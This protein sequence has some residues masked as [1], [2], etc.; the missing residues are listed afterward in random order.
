MAHMTR[1]HNHPLGDNA[2]TVGVT[3]AIGTF[4]LVL[5]ITSTAV[6]GV[7]ARPVAGVPYGSLAV[8]IAGGLALVLLVASLGPVSGAHFNPAVTLGLAANGRFPWRYTPVYVV[9]QFAG[10]IG[11]AA[12]VWSLYGEAAKSKASLGATF[13]APGVAVWRVLVTEAIV[14]FI[15]V[16]VVV[17]VATDARVSGVRRLA[18]SAPP[19]PS[20]SSSADR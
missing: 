16:L 10:A 7:L 5:A 15:L 17:S 4:V 12:I 8:P 3:E 1:L 13:P 11:A 14:T 20:R 18:R 9:S 6:A 19:W 2:L